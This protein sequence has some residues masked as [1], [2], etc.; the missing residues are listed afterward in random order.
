M[1]A[2]TRFGVATTLGMTVGRVAGM[3]VSYIYGKSQE[4]SD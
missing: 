3:G 4:G 2:L 1:Q